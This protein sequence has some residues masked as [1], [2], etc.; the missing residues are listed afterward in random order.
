METG[1][2]HRPG[3]AV[4]HAQQRR[5]SSVHEGAPARV[6]RLT[7]HEDGWL[8]SRHA[9][10]D[11]VRPRSDSVHDR[12]HRNFAG[13]RIAREG[14]RLADDDAAGRIEVLRA[15][16]VELRAIVGQ[17]DDARGGD[18]ERP[19]QRGQVFEDAHARVGED[20]AEALG[21]RG[22]ALGA[23]V[24]GRGNQVLDVHQVQQPAA[25]RQDGLRGQPGRRALEPQRREQ[26]F[27]AMNDDVE[28]GGGVAPVD[29][30]EACAVGG[31]DGDDPVGLGIRGVEAEGR[32]GRKD[33]RG[34][35]EGE[36]SVA[37]AGQVEGAERQRQRGKPRRAKPT[38]QV[39]REER[40]G[41]EQDRRGRSRAADRPDRDE[42]MRHE[43]D[44]AAGQDERH[45]DG[46]HR[47]CRPGKQPA[48]APRARRPG[49]HFE[50]RQAEGRQQGEPEVR[51]GQQ[52]PVRDASQDRRVRR[53]PV[54]RAETVDD[55]EHAGDEDDEKGGVAA[56]AV[57]DRERSEQQ[58]QHSG[59]RGALGDLDARRIRMGAQI[60]REECGDL[61]ERFRPPGSLETAVELTD[62]LER[63]QD[64][65]RG[66]RERER[67]GPGKQQRESR[68]GRRRESRG[69]PR[70]GRSGRRRRSVQR[71]SRG[72]R[73]PVAP[74]A[75]GAQRRRRPGRPIDRSVGAAGDPRPRGP[76]QATSRC[77]GGAAPGTRSSSR[78]SRRSRR[79]SARRR[80]RPRAS[81]RTAPQG[82]PRGSS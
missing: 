75:R 11:L 46:R 55:L 63:R 43:P 1:P 2:D 18:Q 53:E 41:G 8:G 64:L 49:G 21:V 42:G 34:P 40:R 80:A 57:K 9:H 62:E 72:P 82:G 60:A 28:A 67:S 78:R 25:R 39:D 66:E 59:I 16:T 22:Q 27:R 5:W 3:E 54:R 51:H 32:R 33:L 47:E 20:P 45:T 13:G 26:F 10:S 24:P 69:W 50:R 36:V 37:R 17:N 74:P 31:V 4:V 23:P 12:R 52:A 44:P 77:R 15:D 56:V 29:E 81:A 48:C 65:D 6:P 7:E 38:R 58:G 76:A 30:L 35:H 14:R 73:S 71:E 70:G 61:A 19:R 68:G 79:S